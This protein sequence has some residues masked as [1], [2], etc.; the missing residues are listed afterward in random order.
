M[1]PKLQLRLPNDPSAIEDSSAAV[2]RFL[3][4]HGLS[5]RTLHRADVIVE[6]LVSNLVRHGEGVR[7]IFLPASVREGEVELVVEDD[8]EPFNPFERPKPAPFTTLED[9]ELGG[10]GILLVSRFSSSAEYQR[11]GDRN[12]VTVRVAN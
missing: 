5:A 8:G 7:A 12:R 2:G 1:E 4:P 10:L 3:D 11:A 9:A 6:E